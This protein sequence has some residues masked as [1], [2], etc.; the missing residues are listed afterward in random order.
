MF[1][2][3]FGQSV[4]LPAFLS[5][6]LWSW[7]RDLAFGKRWA[8]SESRSKSWFFGL[9]KALKNSIWARAQTRAHPKLFWT[10]FCFLDQYVHLF[11]VFGLSLKPKAQIQNV[12]IGFW[13][14]NMLQFYGFMKPIRELTRDPRPDPKIILDWILGFGLNFRFID[15]LK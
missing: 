2:P 14:L 6:S 12:W 8:S 4:R 1:R 3:V 7:G 5:I 9:C 10:N 11:E 15:F 13:I